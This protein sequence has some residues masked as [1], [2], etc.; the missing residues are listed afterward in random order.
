MV[1]TFMAQPKRKLNKLKESV[2]A[3]NSEPKSTNTEAMDDADYR[4]RLHNAKKE[5]K[6]AESEISSYTA[7]DVSIID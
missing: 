6:K 2:T 3:N 1:E 5:V 7:G 4:A